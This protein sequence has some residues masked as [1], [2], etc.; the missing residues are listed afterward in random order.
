MRPPLPRELQALH[1]YEDTVAV[2]AGERVI[3]LSENLASLHGNASAAGTASIDNGVVRTFVLALKATIRSAN[4]VC[5]QQTLR[6][7]RSRDVSLANGHSLC[8]VQHLPL[9]MGKVSSAN[10]LV[11]VLRRR[12]PCHVAGIHHVSVHVRPRVRSGQRAG[13]GL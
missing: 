1:P 3:T 8:G 9:S 5:R 4:A 6:R 13:R 10:G 11:E 2:D 12:L 7:H